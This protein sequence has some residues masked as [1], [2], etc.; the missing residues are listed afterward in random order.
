MTAL[1]TLELKG[2]VRTVGGRYERRIAGVG[3]HR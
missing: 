3:A 1:L 2:L